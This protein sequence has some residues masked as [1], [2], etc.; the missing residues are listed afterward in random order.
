MMMGFFL[1]MVF[2]SFLHNIN[3][4]RVGVLKVCCVHKQYSN[5]G[6]KVCVKGVRREGMMII[7]KEDMCGVLLRVNQTPERVFSTIW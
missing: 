6:E 7:K 4:E 1:I 2:L 5:A 3:L